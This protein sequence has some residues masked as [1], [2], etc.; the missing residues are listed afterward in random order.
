MTED[1]ILN[2]HAGTEIH[3]IRLPWLHKCETWTVDYKIDKYKGHAVQLYPS[4]YRSTWFGYDCPIDLES[5][6][7]PEECPLHHALPD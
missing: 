3:I 2:L 4:G 5:V 1:Q 6:H 7:L